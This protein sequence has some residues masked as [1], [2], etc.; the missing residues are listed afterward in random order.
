M[1]YDPN[2]LKLIGTLKG[3]SPLENCPELVTW[4]GMIMARWSTLDHTLQLF[5]YA[6]LGDYGIAEAVLY[7]LNPQ[8]QRLKI[9]SALID[10]ATW[11]SA[12]KRA[13]LKL[14][15]E[16]EALADERNDLVHSKTF[17][18]TAFADAEFTA[19]VIK[20]PPRHGPDGA[21]EIQNFLAAN[22]HFN[23]VF[24]KNKFRLTVNR[25]SAITMTK[26]FLQGHADKVADINARLMIFI[27]PLLA[28]RPADR[29]ST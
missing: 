3:A 29:P 26:E 18:G 11:D 20:S 6:I 24:E 15:D 8:S 27:L 28:A 9:I 2:N 17:A 14:I 10:S 12:N 7:W 21:D 23:T 5:V 25:K 13:A 1:S 19:D 22:P 4:L 16:F